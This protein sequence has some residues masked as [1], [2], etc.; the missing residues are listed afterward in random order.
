MLE[1]DQLV[2]A[3]RVS[4]AEAKATTA[5]VPAAASALQQRQTKLLKREPILA[6][7][8][9]GHGVVLVGP[10]LLRRAKPESTSILI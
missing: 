4:A 7:L 10:M 9:E 2:A 6:R 8:P 3:E 5:K 1:L